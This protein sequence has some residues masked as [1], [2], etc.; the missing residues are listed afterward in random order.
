MKW[1][2][3]PHSQIIKR[4]IASL[5]PLL[6]G[7]TSWHPNCSWSKRVL[8]AAGRVEV[9]VGFVLYKMHVWRYKVFIW[10]RITQP[11]STELQW[12]ALLP[13]VLVHFQPRVFLCLRV[14]SRHWIP[15]STNIQARWI[16]ESNL[17]LGVNA[18]LSLFL[19]PNSGTAALTWPTQSAKAVSLD[20]ESQNQ[21]L[22]NET[23]CPMEN[24]QL[25]H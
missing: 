21:A 2:L 20:R 9:L 19:C 7:L 13:Q 15:Q 12:L 11:T 14:R 22:L 4:I 6:T 8:L 16:G 3:C 25:H 17:S 10:D 5:V 24:V 1:D 18:C 23:V